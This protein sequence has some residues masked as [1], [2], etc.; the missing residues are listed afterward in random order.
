MNRNKQ[1][2]IYFFILL[3]SLNGLISQTI[4]FT[5]GN[6]GTSYLKYNI[7]MSTASTAAG[8]GGFTA[9]CTAGCNDDNTYRIL[10]FK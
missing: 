2:L 7:G 8:I 5:P 9:S 4:E 3:F 1:I 6:E 10:N